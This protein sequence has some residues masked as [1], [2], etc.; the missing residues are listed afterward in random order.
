MNWL[1]LVIT[2]LAIGVLVATHRWRVVKPPPSTLD[3]TTPSLFPAPLYTHRTD[4]QYGTS[5]KGVPLV[6]YLSWGTSQIPYHMKRNIER[7]HEANPE[8]DIS[9]NDDDMIRKFLVENYD[10]DVVRTFDCLKPGAY[11]SDFWRYCVLYKNGGVY[12][13][14]KCYPEMSLISIFQE[15]GIPLFVKDLH[16]KKLCVWNGMMITPPK[17]PMFK[18]CIDEVVKIVKAKGYEEDDL[19]IT[20]PCLLGRFFKV[21][22][23]NY[24]FKLRLGWY[25]IED[26]KGVLI[27]TQYKE[28]RAEQKLFQKGINYAVSWRNRDIYAC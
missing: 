2:V 23:P 25:C 22:Y 9:F 16:P 18:M 3:T 28:Y 1:A 17:L 6:I 13:D 5:Y 8:F 15:Y 24:E 10:S 20:G 14:I 7:L 4:H 26:M 11:K 12:M 27:V 19:S 21:F